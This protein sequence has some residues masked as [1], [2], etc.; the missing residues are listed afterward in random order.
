MFSRVWKPDETLA[1][2][3]EIVLNACPNHLLKTAWKGNLVVMLSCSITLYACPNHLLG[4]SPLAL[5]H[6]LERLR[7]GVLSFR[8]EN[9]CLKRDLILRFISLITI[10]FIV[11][12]V[13]SRI[14]T[15]KMRGK[16]VYHSL[17]WL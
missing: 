10:L 11:L 17:F 15:L 5:Y 8:L 3:F 7:I 4:T 16:T 14:G 6:Q 9:I 1:L 12:L 13:R 2:V